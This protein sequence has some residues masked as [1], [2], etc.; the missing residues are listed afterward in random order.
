MDSIS[1]FFKI[2]QLKETIKAQSIQIEY[3]KKK[4]KRMAEIIS[5]ELADIASL[6][7]TLASDES[8][9]AK[10]RSEIPILTKKFMLDVADT[11]CDYYTNLYESDHHTNQKLIGQNRA[12]KLENEALHHLFLNGTKPNESMQTVTWPKY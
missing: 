7:L 12:L 8:S 11:I 3:Y 9:E 10:V 4:C 1:E 2:E 6:H 5:S